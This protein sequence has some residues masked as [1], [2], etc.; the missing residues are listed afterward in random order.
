M[1]EKGFPIYQNADI[2]KIFTYAGPEALKLE[3]YEFYARGFAAPDNRTV[4]THIYWDAS[5]N[6]WMTTIATPD[7]VDASGKHQLLA[8]VDVL[9]DELMERTAKPLMQ[10]A[11]STI[12]MADS[13]GTLLYHPRHLAQIKSSEGKASIRSLKIDQDYPLLAVIPSLSAGKA[14]VVRER[15]EIVAV[16]MIPG[17]PWVLAVHYPQDLMRSAILDNLLIVIALGVLTLLVEIFILRA[18]LQKQVA[19]PL[20]RLMQATRRLGVRNER[21]ERESLPIRLNDEIGELA[22]DFASMADRVHN[23][24]QQLETKVRDRTAALEAANRQLQLLSTTDG[25]TGIANRRRFDEVLASAWSASQRAGT[26]LSVALIDVD[27]FKRYNDHHGHQA[28]DDCLRSVA[29]T[30]AA[31]ALRADDLVARY[32]GEEFA[33][34]ASTHRHAD[35][36]LHHA[37]T[38][39]SAVEKL[40]LSHEMSPFGRVTV[41]VG[42]ACVI[43]TEGRTVGDMLEDA[44]RALYRAKQQGRNQAVIA[45]G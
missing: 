29:R 12:S 40:A 31:Q 41:S 30:L 4:F 5:N 2:A 45:G 23:A 8:C 34:I 1:R 17:T 43:P 35:G 38:L 18:I 27:W 20:A 13:E 37:R 19:A 24:H 11:Y 3:T 26:L 16:G 9:L 15:D 44:D 6:A 39:C 32:G 21:L 7:Q 28:G 42:V 25:L 10:G 33:L 36:A 22:R 14:V